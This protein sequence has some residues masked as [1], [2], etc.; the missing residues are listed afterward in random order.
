MILL[1]YQCYLDHMDSAFEYEHQ[2][3]YCCKLGM[4]NYKEP[5]NVWNERKWANLHIMYIVINSLITIMTSNFIPKVFQYKITLF[6]L[7][8]KLL[9]LLNLSTHVTCKQIFPRCCF[10]KIRRM[11]FLPSPLFWSLFANNRGISSQM[12]IEMANVNWRNWLSQL[13]SIRSIYPKNCHTDY[14]ILSTLE[15]KDYSF[16]NGRLV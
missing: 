1:D 12:K 8:G 4:C 16:V 13:A 11:V 2:G 9:G 14:R 7:L 5:K 10:Y 3:H 6:N 15:Q